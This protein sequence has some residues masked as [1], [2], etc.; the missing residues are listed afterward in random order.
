MTTTAQA[1]L[2]AAVVALVV[3]RQFRTRPVRPRMY[4]WV[5]VLVLLGLAPPGPATATAAGIGVLAATLAV[6]VGFGWWRGSAMPIWRDATGRVWRRG[7]RLLLLL[8]LATVATR[9]GVEAFAR[10]VL[11]EPFR[12]PALYL[13]FGVTIGVQHLVT[14]H[15]GA[16]LPAPQG[17]LTRI[18]TGT[19]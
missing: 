10:G 1:L 12:L 3:V 17:G 13:G 19:P 8:W 7:G 6:S 9:I 2:I 4:V 15:R 11:H 18:A 14:S 16:R 5:L